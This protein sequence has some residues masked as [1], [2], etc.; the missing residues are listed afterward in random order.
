MIFLHPVIT[1]TQNAMTCFESLSRLA[2]LRRSDRYSPDIGPFFQDRVSCPKT[3]KSGKKAVMMHTH[4]F[5]A[6]RSMP[7]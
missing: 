1:A 5:L 4:I 6:C 2:R 7:Q 3:E